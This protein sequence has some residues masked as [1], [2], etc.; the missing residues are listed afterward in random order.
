MAPSE[1]K[2]GQAGSVGALLELT[3]QSLARL[4]QL[5]FEFAQVGVDQAPVFF[6]GFS[7]ND[8]GVDVGQARLHDHGADRVVHG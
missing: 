8:H 6:S 4:N 5:G 2:R 7:S 1:V 3:H